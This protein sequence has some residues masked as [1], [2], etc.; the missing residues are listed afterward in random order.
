MHGLR[1]K[2]A[3]E[4]ATRRVGK[5]AKKVVQIMEGPDLEDMN[6]PMG[7]YTTYVS[8]HSTQMLY[9]LAS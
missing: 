8:T 2:S 4:C 5:H 7:L 9:N 1:S 3:N 6:R